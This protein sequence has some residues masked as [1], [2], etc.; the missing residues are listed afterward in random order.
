MAAATETTSVAIEATVPEPKLRALT[1]VR[2][3]KTTQI[4]AVT[5]KMRAAIRNGVFRV[6]TTTGR[7]TF[8]KPWQTTEGPGL[9]RGSAFTTHVDYDGEG[10]DRIAVTLHVVTNSHVV[11]S[12]IGGA[13]LLESD[14][15]GEPFSAH[16]RLVGIS[17]SGDRSLKRRGISAAGHDVARLELD[18]RPVREKL[19]AA[20]FKKLTFH[21]FPLAERADVDILTPAI[22][23]GHPIGIRDI[24]TMQ[25]TITSLLDGIDGRP[26]IGTDAAINPG[27]SG[28][29]LIII[30]M[31]PATGE[32]FLA[33]AGINSL[34]INGGDNLGFAIPAWE[35][36]TILRVIDDAGAF[37]FARARA[38]HPD[39]PVPPVV[40]HNPVAG[41]VA[42]LFTR[43]SAHSRNLARNLDCDDPVL[44]S[45]VGGLR[46]SSVLNRTAIDAMIDDTNLVRRSTPGMEPLPASTLQTVFGSLESEDKERLQRG[47]IITHVGSGGDEF[48]KL[49]NGRIPASDTNNVDLEDLLMSLRFGDLFRIRVLRPAPLPKEVGEQ[50]SEAPKSIEMSMTWVH[51]DERALPIREVFPFV[52]E[53]RDYIVIGGLVLMSLTLN[54]ISPLIGS[55]PKLGEFGELRNRIIPRVI[56]SDL[57]AVTTWSQTN[58]RIRGVLA[59]ESVDGDIIISI[60]GSPVNTL[61][62]V[63][64]IM[65]AALQRARINKESGDGPLDRCV[66]Y[67]IL[68]T[69]LVDKA[70]REVEMARAGGNPDAQPDP[71][72]Y[73]VADTA[74][75]ELELQ[76]MLRYAP[77]P[78]GVAYAL[79]AVATD[80]AERTEK[81]LGQGEASTSSL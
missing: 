58:V 7:R 13:I 6:A 78:L 44:L 21:A 9:S 75:D 24:F 17:P 42:R 2:K 76:A 56:L 28:G 65:G 39:E 80:K 23:A 61:E 49:D 14:A 53:A 73:S 41:M 55:Y 32:R 60:D 43:A 29:P 48:R 18:L 16:V 31:D 36:Q 77:T 66:T 70:A 62:D 3:G 54:H 51:L 47:D 45:A 50:P 5:N 25:G 74:D 59:K 52:R 4:D 71:V 1:H 64:K 63:R 15:L 12:V 10:E 27:N 8:T 46:V 34:G 40:I 19:G 26:L 35:V 37:A 30:K 57:M 38:L 22:V 20:A 33:V 69:R 11:E 79:A 67:T 72:V 68:T 81:A